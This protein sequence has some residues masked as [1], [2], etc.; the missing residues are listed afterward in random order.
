MAGMAHDP[1]EWWFF[2]PAVEW[3]P[4]VTYHQGQR[5]LICGHLYQC[6]REHTSGASFKDDS[7]IR[8][9]WIWKEKV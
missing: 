9:V 6:R 2:L 3:E 7:L 4:H 8:G 5:V 1:R